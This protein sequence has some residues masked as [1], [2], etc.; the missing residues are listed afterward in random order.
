MQLAAPLILSGTSREQSRPRRAK[1]AGSRLRLGQPMTRQIWVTFDP[2]DAAFD[3][4]LATA[5]A[6]FEDGHYGPSVVAAQTACEV[7]TEE[8]IS[9]WFIE[10]RV[11]QGGDRRW[12]AVGEATME[13]FRTFDLNNE[14]LRRM[15]VIVSNDQIHEQPFW[16]RYVEHV[17]RRHQV[18]HRGYVTTKAEA[19]KS[20]AVAKEFVE[21][22]K[23]TFPSGPPDD[24]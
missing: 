22:V 14:G 4:L 6:L 8:A 2:G 11:M 15:Y 16:S 13:S 20:L 17:R 18:V 3:V 12:R 9:F 21:H 10:M 24:E 23:T 7:I 19:R 5:D 1:T